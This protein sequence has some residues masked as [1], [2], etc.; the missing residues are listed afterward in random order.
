M[1]AG[2]MRTKSILAVVLLMP[3]I[4]VVSQP[5]KRSL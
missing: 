3:V 4:S 5:D 2:M 1:L